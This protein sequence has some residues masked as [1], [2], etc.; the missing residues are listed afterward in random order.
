[1]MLATAVLAASLAIVTQDQVALRA[2]PRDSAQQQTVLWQGDSLEIRGEKGDFLQVWDH[3]RERGG[4]VRASQVRSYAMD[5]ESAARMLAVMGFVRD[6]A[7]AEALGIGHTAAFLKAA[8]AEAI[9]PEAFD[10]LGTLADRL[11]RRASASRGRAGDNVTAAHLE[12]AASYGV[13]M[14]SFE[15]DGR[16]QICY[17]GEAFRRVMALPKS[18][19]LQRARAALALTRHDCVN[20]DLSPTDR[21]SLDAWRMEVLQRV[22]TSKLPEHLKNRIQMRRAGVY[23]SLAFQQ[24][25]RGESAREAAE[26][27]IAS[28]AAVNKSELTED[29]A[30]AYS[31]AAARAGAI[32][33]ATATPLKLASGLTVQTR[34]GQP[35]ETCV[36]LSDG[37]S[38]TPLAE[39]CTWGIVWPASATANPQRNMLALAVQPLDGWRELWLFRQ[40][41]QGWRIDVVPP[42]S[43]GPDI[44]YIEF[45]GWV[46]GGKQILTA[47]EV[48]LDGRYKRSFE[49][50]SLESFQVERWADKPESLSA[51]Y[52]WQDPVWKKLTLAVR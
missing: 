38:K 4:Y 9:G 51:F 17:N 40:E 50:L 20:P 30:Y 23:A 39:R 12:V 8:P 31:D 6:T 34:A 7:G 43:N 41:A 46:P 10:A 47:R 15:R 48:R 32:R 27:A 2:A 18:S 33:W 28:L 22:D 25:R 1:M 29:D 14:E 24:A 11:A 52:R 36:S 21:A 49:L 45:A 16:V 35:G 3:R 19:D 42:S 26:Q 5:H 37:K 13:V 44:G